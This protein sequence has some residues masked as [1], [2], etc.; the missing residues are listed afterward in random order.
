MAPGTR[1]DRDRL[2]RA[3]RLAQL[4]GDAAFLAVGISAKRML[5]PEP[6]G[7]GILLEGIVDRCLRREEVAQGKAEGG[8]ELRQ[9]QRATGLCQS[10]RLILLA[11]P[12]SCCAGNRR[13]GARRKE[14]PRQAGRRAPGTS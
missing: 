4:A 5:A 1:L 7:N 13:R 6:R 9:E 12:P 11:K 3:D 2:R 8:E 10:H 14:S